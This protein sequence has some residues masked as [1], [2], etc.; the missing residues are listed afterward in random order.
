[1]GWPKRTDESKLTR[2]ELNVIALAARGETNGSIA[3]KLGLSEE[4]VKSR[5]ARARRAVRARTMAHLVAI[6]LSRG[7][8]DPLGEE[9][10]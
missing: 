10:R 4:G 3:R 9:E 6:C 5:T 1:M 7:L 8:I 2:R